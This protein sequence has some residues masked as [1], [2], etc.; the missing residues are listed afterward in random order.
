[1]LKKKENKVG[2]VRASDLLIKMCKSR[3]VNLERQ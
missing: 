3:K 1:M 2:L